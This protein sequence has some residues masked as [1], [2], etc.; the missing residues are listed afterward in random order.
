MQTRMYLRGML[1]DLKFAFR[2]FAKSPAFAGIAIFTPA[3]GIG[4]TA[5]MFSAL[6]APVAA[7]LSYPKQW[8]VGS[9][10]N[11]L[12]PDIPCE[13]PRPNEIKTS[14]IGGYL[15]SKRH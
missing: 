2:S 15:A 10:L 9:N 1:A 8:T 11:F 3:L 4:S 6:K 12:T 7:P 5:A 14:S 13:R